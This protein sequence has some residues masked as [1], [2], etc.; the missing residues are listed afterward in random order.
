LHSEEVI[1]ANEVLVDG[2]G[3]TQPVS[4]TVAVSNPGLTDTE[5]RA[6]PVPV[7]GPLTDTEL[8]ATPVPVSGTVA[9]SNF[10]GASVGTATVSRVAV[11]AVVATLATSNASRKKL[12]VHNETGTL[13]VK[14]GTGATSTDYSYRLTANALLELDTYYGEVTAIKATGSTF[15]QVTEL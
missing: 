12:I 3:H 9:V 2:S 15:A 4:G 6:T 10:P 5:L 8:R 14:L 1:V 7:S 13:F 11:S